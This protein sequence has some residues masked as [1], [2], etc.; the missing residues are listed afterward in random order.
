MVFAK[1]DNYDV[2]IKSEKKEI[3]IRVKTPDE[4]NEKSN[5]LVRQLREKFKEHLINLTIFNRF[6]MDNLKLNNLDKFRNHIGQ[7]LKLLVK[8]NDIDE[9]KSKNGK[10]FYI[11][12]GELP[13][14]RKSIECIY[15]PFESIATIQKDSFYIMD[16]T[17]EKVNE[18]KMFIK[19]NEELLGKDKQYQFKIR[20]MEK[21]DYVE[22]IQKG[23]YEIPRQ[24]LHLHTSYSKNDAFI[25]TK[26]IEKAFDENKVDAIALT[27]HGAVFSFI[28]FINELKKKYKDTD[29]KLY[30]GS[31]FYAGDYLEY[32]DEINKKII[33]L[34]A[35]Q[36]SLTDLTH[37]DELDLIREEITNL[38]RDR[39]SL[40]RIMAR[41]TATELDKEDASV[42]LEEVLSE[43]ESKELEVS[44][45]K[46]SS[47]EVDERLLQIAKEVEY[48]KGQIDSTS[49]MP[50]DHIT[51]ILKS[52]DTEIDYRGE[53]LTINPG[54]IQLYKLITMSYDKYF[55]SPVDSK[56]KK[57]GKRPILPYHELFKEGVREHFII[58]SACAFGKHMKLAVDGKWD[59]FKEWVKNLDAVELQPLHNN[60]YMV[61][62]ADYPN[63]NSIDD[64]CTLHYDIYRA[65]KEV[66]VPVIFTSDAHVNDEEDRVFRARF[67]E[68]Y[69]TNIKNK[70]Q[71]SRLKKIAKGE[72]V[73]PE[74]T[75]D[76]DDFSIEKQPF[77]LS[78]EDVITELRKQRFADSVVCE[79][80]E[81]TKKIA[82]KCK[83]AFEMTILPKKF[84][85]GDF[86]GVN[87]KEE[88]PNL[89]W[90]FAVNKWSKN[91]EKDGID[92]L[93]LR[94]LETEIEALQK[95]GY[96]ILY[97]IAYWSC[98]KS[99]E[100]GYVVGSRGSCGSML[101]TYCLQVG[102]N[103]PLEPHYFCPS[104]KKIEW[105]DT[106]LIG[107]DLPTK[108]CD[109]GV[110]M[111]NDGCL[112]EAHN[113]LGYNLDK[114]ADI[115]L[116][117]S[118]EVQSA[119]HQLTKDVFG[120]ENIIKSGTQSFYQENAL[121]SNIFKHIPNIKELVRNEDFDIDYMSINTTVMS[122]TGQHPGGM[123]L[124]PS[125]I[126]FEYITPL[127]YVSDD[128]KKKEVSSFV[129]YHNL[130]DSLPKLDM[131]GHS[132]PTM[133]KE[134]KD[135]TGVDYKTIKFNDP[136]MYEAILDSNYLGIAPEDYPFPSTTMAISEMNSDF[137]MGVLAEIKPKNMTDMIYFSGVTHG[138]GC[139]L[140]NSLRGRVINGESKLQDGFP[141]RDIIYQHLTR[142]FNW[143]PTEAFAISESVRKGKGIKKWESELRRKL[144][145][146]MV[147]SME[148]IKYAFPKA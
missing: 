25:T 51:V 121:K 110:E 66:G 42:K 28:P 16:G 45:I 68:G 65:C 40:K 111:E 64:V 74:E 80:L 148:Q 78:W 127:V 30:L 49:D 48:L 141:V 136:K 82:D 118:S 140:N 135:L 55:S 114:A 70:V 27:D 129:D 90:N 83:N 5:E 10:V 2:I 113:F 131:L 39:D 14:K 81:N 72:E 122:T 87:V 7:N 9:K 62:N 112:I 103:N 126:P 146:W 17:L 97:Y 77:I 125:D 115:D 123:L 67:K 60:S 76:D 119:I 29:K 22:S 105:V 109:C 117:F 15:F 133:L 36:I 61:G 71:E 73:E 41:K 3:E 26:D 92:P 144:P 134:L 75:G 12:K 46:E 32:Q 54:L 56:M 139:W 142:K 69:I 24:E 86:P 13:G 31:E 91:G 37:S 85:L 1:V 20:T 52:D 11:I 18:N 79:I 100:L 4:I 50:R 128:P 8:I 38:R 108:I 104:C 23:L 58:N 132:D 94:R 120:E 59:E 88:V 130:E 33:S 137:T 6:S 89:I 21:Y 96:E 124:K 143:D 145:T 34:E 147:E 53:K 43:I 106:D 44:K 116:N 84:F 63:I 93:I 35:E 138:T 47:K 101:I 102:E 57:Y 99:E 19:K 107:L 98:R 95:T